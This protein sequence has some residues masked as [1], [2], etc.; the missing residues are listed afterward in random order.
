MWEWTRSVDGKK[1][2]YRAAPE[3]ETI[4][5]QNQENMVVRGGAYYRNQ[6]LCSSRFGDDPRRFLGLRGVRVVVSPF[7]TADL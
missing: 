4:N 6:N 1:F 2:P 5:S 3:Y 7:F